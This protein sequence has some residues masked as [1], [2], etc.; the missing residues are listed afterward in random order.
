MEPSSD[1]LV[2]ELAAEMQL[3]EQL[4]NSVGVLQQRVV[5]AETKLLKQEMHCESDG[6]LVEVVGAIA[7]LRK[8]IWPPRGV[9]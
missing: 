7:D 9:P 8:R 1:K 4:K 6:N 3:Q 5:D 2:M